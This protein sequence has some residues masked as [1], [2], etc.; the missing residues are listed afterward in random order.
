M[1][2]DID[3]YW[4][5]DSICDFWWQLQKFKLKKIFRSPSCDL[6]HFDAN[7]AWKMKIGV[8]IFKNWKIKKIKL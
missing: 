8:V 2:D 3:V 7:F 4:F 5:Y 6:E 1:Y